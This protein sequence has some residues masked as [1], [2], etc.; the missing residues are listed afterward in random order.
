MSEIFADINDSRTVNFAFHA[1]D[2]NIGFG[3]HVNYDNF[4]MY[5]ADTGLFI[6]MAFMDKDY[7]DN[8]IYRKLLSDKLPVDLGYIYENVVAQALRSAGHALHYYTFKTKQS[9]SGVDARTYE[10]DFLISLHDKICPIEVKSSG[11][12]THRS[13]DLF[14]E[15][16]S[17]RIKDSYLLYTKD[18]K[19]E[20]G[21]IYLPVYMASLLK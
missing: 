9:D 16:Y 10:I 12:R 7:T 18:L 2:P 5:L 17:S 21:L 20:N 6:T 13:L 15:K 8:N 3:L 1:D 19:C 11:Y 4:K 14:R